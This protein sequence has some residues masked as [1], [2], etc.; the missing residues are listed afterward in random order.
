MLPDLLFIECLSLTTLAI[1]SSICFSARENRFIRSS[2]SMIPINL[3]LEILMLV[4]NIGYYRVF[5]LN[6]RESHIFILDSTTTRI[7]DKEDW[8]KRFSRGLKQIEKI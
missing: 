7:I 1:F 5:T 6:L 3:L 2:L 4:S 8:M